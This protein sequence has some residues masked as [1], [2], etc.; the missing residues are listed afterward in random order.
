MSDKANHYDYFVIGGGS[1]GI[2]SARRAASYGAKTAIVEGNI[3]GGTCVNVGCVPK[4]V[5]WNCAD[6][7]ATLNVSSDYG[8]DIPKEAHG[9]KWPIIKKKRDEYIK[10]LNGIYHNNLASSKVDEFAGYAKFTGLKTVE[11]EGKTYTA[12]HILIAAGGYPDLPDIPGAEHGITSDGFFELEDLPK[13]VVVVGAGYIAVEMAGMLHTLG[14][15]TTIV[16]RNEQFLR[17]FDETLRTTLHKEMEEK[18]PKVVKKTEIKSVT[19]KEDGTLTLTTNNNEELSGF[20]CLLWAVG[21]K[22]RTKQLDLDKAGV[23]LN[24]LGFIQT[25][26]YQNTTAPGVYSVGD[27]SGRVQ[28]TPVAIAAGRRLSDRLFGGKAG[29]KLSY[30]DVPSVVFSHPPI[31]TVGLTEEQAK[32]KYGEKNIKIYMS[33]FTNM[34]FSVSTTK[35]KTVMKLVCV[36]PEERIVG[37]HVIGKGADEMVQGF[38]VAVKMRATKEDFDNTV[39]IHP[40][41]SEEFVTMR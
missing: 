28:L 11:V 1:G 27:I 34:Y 17:S 33:S 39:A 3:I 18:G 19:K 41:A 37:L 9:F 36:L 40:T 10:R 16:I 32:E 7:R 38:S 29:A 23:R 6:V 4:K 20:D 5:M 24:E 14:A 2:A 15:D 25:D 12:D 8:F 35:E 21:R 22:P 26:E 31:G 30:D 13:K